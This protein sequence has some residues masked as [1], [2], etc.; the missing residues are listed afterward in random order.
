MSQ[1]SLGITFAPTDLA[2]MLDLAPSFMVVLR[3]P[4]FVVE[5]ANKAYHQ[6]VGRRQLVGLP[7]REAFPDIEGQGFLE[8][9]ESVYATGT[10]WVGNSVPIRLERVPEAP[11]E[12]RFLDLVYQALRGADGAITGIFAHGVDI[13]DRRVAEEALREAGELAEQQT[14]VFNATLSAVTDSV[15]TFNV[16][17]RFLYANKALLDL[18]QLSIENLV[19]K[20]FLELGYPKDLAAK[21]QDQIQHVFESGDIVIDE[22]P[23]VGPD[24]APGHYEYIFSPVLDPYAKVKMVAGST[25]DITARK[26]AEQALLESDRRKSDFLAMLAHELRNPLA[27]IRTGVEFLAVP[28]VRTRG[29]LP[30]SR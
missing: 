13:T 4:A 11:P 29:L 12:V 18:L 24:G 17:G 26:N 23:F 22:T 6:L 1:D 21:L 3:G 25:R 14:R 2:E 30:C 5:V 10:P 7:V 15:Y 9:L 19:G 27:P 16:D 20:D 8:R 28:A